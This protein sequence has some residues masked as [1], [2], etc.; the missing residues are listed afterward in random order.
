M[1]VLPAT[2]IWA[3]P[4]RSAEVCSL[5]SG[6]GGG[7]GVNRSSGIAKGLSAPRWPPVGDPCKHGRC[8]QLPAKY[9]LGMKASASFLERQHG[10]LAMHVRLCRTAMPFPTKSLRCCDSCMG[11]RAH[12]P[13]RFVQMFIINRRVHISVSGALGGCTT[14]FELA[15]SPHALGGKFQPHLLAVIVASV[16]G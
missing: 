2:S 4:S 10:F 15:C 11:C 1:T 8:A 6:M 7:V 13:Q 16:H 14:A 12:L 9:S 5:P 3:Q